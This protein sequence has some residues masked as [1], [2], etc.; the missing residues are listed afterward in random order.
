MRFF[1]ESLVT[2]R[3]KIGIVDEIYDDVYLVTFLD[4]S[5]RPR[6]NDYGYFL[7]EEL[8]LSI[9]CLAIIKKLLLDCQ[10]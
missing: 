1:I 5:F 8:I 6:E 9:Y 3:G 10:G 4:E 2:Y 7:D